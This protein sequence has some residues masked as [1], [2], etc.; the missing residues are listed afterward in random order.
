MSDGS[1]KGE[2]RDAGS[3]EQLLQSIERYIDSWSPKK[4]YTFEFNLQANHNH[5]R[6]LLAAWIEKNREA[7][8]A[9]GE[10]KTKNEA[11]CHMLEKLMADYA[12][13]DP[14]ELVEIYVSEER[15][16]EGLKQQLTSKQHYHEETKRRQKKIRRIEKKA[17]GEKGKLEMLRT[18]FG[19]LKAFE[20]KSYETAYRLLAN[21]L[22][23]TRLDGILLTLT[24]LENRLLDHVDL[25]A[26]ILCKLGDWKTK[27]EADS[28]CINGFG[29][30][31]LPIRPGADPHK[32][33]A[34]R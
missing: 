7:N 14:K 25:R 5:I 11:M 3:V 29:P 26:D 20:P 13:L 21:E 33:T 18:I 28:V 19:E 31:R 4:G 23:E 34:R 9:I 30:R 32:K 12:A 15:K 8:A 24:S 17:S 6:C 2:Y 10:K 1:V 16:D 27:K 22:R